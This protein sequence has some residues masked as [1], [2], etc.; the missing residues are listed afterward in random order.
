MTPP[1]LQ[2]RTLFELDALFSSNQ[3]AA[4]LTPIRHAGSLTRRSLAQRGFGTQRL[5]E[6]ES[7]D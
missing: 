6:E 7:W 4:Q 1:M 3:I 5:N 2:L